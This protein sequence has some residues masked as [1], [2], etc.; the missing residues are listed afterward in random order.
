MKFGMQNERRQ[1]IF[2]NYTGNDGFAFRASHRCIVYIF[3][4]GM[5]I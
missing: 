1:S 4:G 3:L 5:L 2:W